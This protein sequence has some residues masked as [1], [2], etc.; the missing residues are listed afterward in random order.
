MK[1]YTINDD[2]KNILE[3]NFDQR[4]L[5][6]SFLG[7]IFINNQC[8]AVRGLLQH[9]MILPLLSE[10]DFPC[11]IQGSVKCCLFVVLC[12]SAPLL[13]YWRSDDTSFLHLLPLTT[14]VLNCIWMNF[15]CVSQH[16]YT[17]LPSLL[18]SGLVR[19]FVDKLCQTLI[20]RPLPSPEDG[21]GP[22]DPCRML[23]WIL[24]NS[25]F[26]L[27]NSPMFIEFIVITINGIFRTRL[28]FTFFQTNRDSF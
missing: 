26:W 12:D 15:S 19:L 17:A 27:L 18:F 21:H 28:A 1:S 3:H 13:L 22:S 2:D 5:I 6:D 7:K 14:V 11:L 16:V 10:N 4:M 8:P 20:L 23:T 25:L 9:L 24:K